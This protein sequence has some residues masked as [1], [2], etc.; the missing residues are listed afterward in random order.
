MTEYRGQLVQLVTMTTTYSFQIR[1]PADNHSGEN[2]KYSKANSETEETI[3]FFPYAFFIDFKTFLVIS[4][5]GTV[6][7][8]LIS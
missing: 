1:Q 4:S 2:L 6:N 8:V 7:N 3:H 5:I